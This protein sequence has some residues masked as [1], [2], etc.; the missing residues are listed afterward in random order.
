MSFGNA[1]NVDK[2]TGKELT[3]QKSEKHL[4]QQKKN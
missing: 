1:Q 3:G 2:S 4:K